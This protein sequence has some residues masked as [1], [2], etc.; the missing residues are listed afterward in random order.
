MLSDSEEKTN[1]RLQNDMNFKLALGFGRCGAVRSRQSA[2][3]APRA[4]L[5]CLIYARG[6][7]S[8]LPE[9]VSV[10]SPSPVDV[11]TSGCAS[12]ATEMSSAHAHAHPANNSRAQIVYCLLHSR[13][14]SDGGVACVACDGSV[15]TWSR[16]NCPRLHIAVATGSFGVAA[17]H[18]RPRG[19]P[20]RAH[21]PRQPMAPRGW[22]RA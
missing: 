19:G 21:P 18:T 11:S 14:G 1:L 15:A 6:R 10:L 12:A 16:Q 8:Q 2:P 22:D 5:P 3:G 20:L 17:S 13:V 4:I 7:S 9:L